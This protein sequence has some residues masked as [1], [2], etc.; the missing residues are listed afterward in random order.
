M[1]WAG[2][3]A[4]FLS[5]MEANRIGD[6][7]GIAGISISLIGFTVTVIGML[8]SKSAAERAEKA[9]R[10]TRDAIRLLDTVVD[11]STAISTLEEIKRLHRQANWALLP[12]R[13]A[14]IRKV[15]VILRSSNLMLTD[16]QQTVV[17]EALANLYSIETTVE[18]ALAGQT[19]P[20]T[21]KINAI[22]SSDIDRLLTVLAELKASKIGV[23][24]NGA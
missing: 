8:R 19:L 13:Y 18:R 12:D 17:Q 10:E 24:N 9:A 1:N 4:A 20:K 16:P 2:Q 11:F 21:P 3:Y 22:I 5:W 6:L 7:S 14:S 23:G 15:L